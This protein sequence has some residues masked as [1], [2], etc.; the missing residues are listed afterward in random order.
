MFGSRFGPFIVDNLPVCGQLDLLY[1][2]Q[3]TI[4]PPIPNDFRDLA[5]FFAEADERIGAVFYLRC[6]QRALKTIPLVEPAIW[7]ALSSGKVLKRPDPFGQ[8]NRSLYGDGHGFVEI[9]NS[10]MML[11]ETGA[12]L[13]QS[14]M[15]K[16]WIAT[17]TGQSG[18]YGSFSAWQQRGSVAPTLSPSP[19][20]STLLLLTRDMQAENEKNIR[21]QE[22]LRQREM[23]LDVARMAGQA[24]GWIKRGGDIWRSSPEERDAEADEE[25]LQRADLADIVQRF[26]DGTLSG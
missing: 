1:E 24:V 5:A 12:M 20:A 19:T 4:V 14:Y 21:I 15:N 3:K 18:S 26:Q 23:V 2:G 7:A 13:C 11:C 8:D 17:K 16:R 10:K 22:I 9:L 25:R 6:S